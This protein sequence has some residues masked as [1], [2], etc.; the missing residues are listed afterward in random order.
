MGRHVVVAF[1]FGLVFLCLS[2]PL[3]AAPPV[4]LL[5]VD[6]FEGGQQDKLGGFHPK[7]QAGD[8]V[9]VIA[10]DANARRGKSGSSLSVQA[11]RRVA[12]YCGV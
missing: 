2:S 5:L 1:V 8:S 9:A 4:K 3:N 7:Y 6:D 10:R 11:D 12:G